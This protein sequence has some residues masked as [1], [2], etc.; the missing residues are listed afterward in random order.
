MFTAWSDSAVGANAAPAAAPVASPPAVQPAQPPA[1]D[2]PSPERL[3]EIR[4]HML[5]RERAE[6]AA[7][8]VLHST[9]G[10]AVSA[11][12][13]SSNDG[14]GSSSRPVE[15]VLT[16]LAPF[17]IPLVDKRANA[18]TTTAAAAADASNAQRSSALRLDRQLDRRLNRRRKRSRRF[19][20][21]RVCLCASTNSMFADG[22]FGAVA[23]AR[24]RGRRAISWRH[25]QCKW[26]FR[27]CQRCQRHAHAR[28]RAASV[29]IFDAIDGDQQQTRQPT[30]ARDQA[31]PGFTATATRFSRSMAP[32]LRRTARP[33]TTMSVRSSRGTD[34]HDILIFL[35]CCTVA[36]ACLVREYVA[37]VVC[38]VFC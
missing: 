26:I 30:F 6:A 23:S 18:A 2:L 25:W 4:D 5:A 11:Q 9:S 16:T 10:S 33:A 1:D 22:R 3:A 19:V 15:S 7:A 37:D 17:D 28:A 32:R 38:C 29:R 12:P 13:A 35:V 14:G 36:R 27:G 34:T 24:I 20:L 21:C 31:A 8:S